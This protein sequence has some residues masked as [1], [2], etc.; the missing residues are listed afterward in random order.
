MSETCSRVQIGKNLSEMFPV[1][2]GLKQRDAVLPFFFNLALEY[3]KRKFQVNHYGLKLNGTHQL[4]FY[5]EVA[6]IQ[7]LLRK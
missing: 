6:Y 3:A 2:N 4:L 7:G 5:G 1:R